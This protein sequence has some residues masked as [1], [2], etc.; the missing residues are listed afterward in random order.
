M[1]TKHFIFIGLLALSFAACNINGSSNSTP[2]LSIVTSHIK[3]SDVLNLYYTDEG[4]VLRLDTI[5]VGDTIVFRM[6]LNGITNNLT[7]FY[8]TQ[9]DTS[10]AKII[11]PVFN[12]M[13]SIFSK[14]QSDYGNGKFIFLPKKI[15]VY[16]PIRF[17]AKKPTNTATIQLSLTSDANFENSIGS[18]KLGMKLKTP[19]IV[20]STTAK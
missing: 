15:H 2:E 8:L 6:D 1:K 16:F 7:S 10:V 17:V 18:N 14:D 5:Q 3:Q 19:I 11:L 9:S 20:K 13:D 12:S 4:G